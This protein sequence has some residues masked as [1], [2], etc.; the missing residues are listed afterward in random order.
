MNF[1]HHSS[2]LSPQPKYHFSLDSNSINLI[3]SLF[4]SLSSAVS[5]ISFLP[6]P[7]QQVLL[8]RPCIDLLPNLLPS[9]LPQLH[10]QPS[11]SCHVTFESEEE[12]EQQW[13][14]LKLRNG[15]IARGGDDDEE[16]EEEEMDV[17]KQQQVPIGLSSKLR[18]LMMMNE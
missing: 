7:Q 18:R 14:R 1:N 3:R 12:L 11:N 5:S 13:N 2:T 17:E 8:Q 6:R 16:E 9:S 4:P 10:H 15:Q